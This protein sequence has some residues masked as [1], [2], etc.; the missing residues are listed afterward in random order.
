MDELKIPNHIGLIVDGNGRWAQARGLKRSEGHKAGAD[1]MDRLF[2]YM[3]KRGV[4]IVSAYVFSTE[5]FK[6]SKEEVDYLMNMVLLRFKKYIKKFNKENIKILVSG[7]REGLRQDVL[8]AMDELVESTKNNTNGIVN[9]CL[10]YGGHAEIIDATKKIYEDAK[11][12]KIDIN[13]LNEE[14]FS[15]YL[16]NELPPIDFMIR[17]S[18]ENRI[19]NFMLWQNSYAEF[20]FPKTLFPDFDEEEFEKALIEFNKRDRRFGGIKYEN[21]NN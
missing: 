19:S 8:D 18:G 10:N 14:M 16:Y 1:N 17:T 2:S 13:E 11:N 20:Y 6:R 9:F 21:K 4:K 3:L 15:K 12:N 7:R 5:N